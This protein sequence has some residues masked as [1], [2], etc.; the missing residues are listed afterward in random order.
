MAANKPQPSVG[1]VVRRARV[2]AGMTQEQLAIFA[3]LKYRTSINHIERGRWN[4]SA[5][6]LAR[7]LGVCHR[8]SGR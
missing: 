3:G 6:L 8:A 4:P 1:D 2:R 5:E 7:I